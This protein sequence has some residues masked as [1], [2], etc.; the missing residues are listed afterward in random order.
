MRVKLIPCF[1]VNNS[2]NVRKL[3]QTDFYSSYS[4][5]FTSLA[6]DVFLDLVDT[7]LTTNEKKKCGGGRSLDQE[8]EDCVIAPI[9]PM[10]F[11]HSYTMPGTVPGSKN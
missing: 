4:K 8:A 5:T 2:L 11:L 9:S 1:S 7:L 10:I 3:S 6:M